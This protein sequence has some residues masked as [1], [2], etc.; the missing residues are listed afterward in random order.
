VIAKLF[1]PG[2]EAHLGHS[3]AAGIVRRVI[4]LPEAEVE[5]LAGQLLTDFSA[6][7]RNY[8]A[9]LERHA[10]IVAA[11]LGDRPSLST[12]R[13][14]VLGAVFTAEYSSEAAALFNPSAVLAPDQD[15][16]G[17][18]QA[19]AALSLRAVGE[20]HVSS[21]GFCTAVV[22]P[23]PLW[24]FEPRARPV[25]L[26]TVSSARWT[27]GRLRAAL[28]GH[29]ALDEVSR[30]LL[31][32]LPE[33]FDNGNLEDAV[34]GLYPELSLRPGGQERI[35]L[36]R[37]LVHSAYATTFD[38]DVTLSQ[39]LLHPSAA[40]ESNGMEDARFTRFVGED[41]GVEYRAT[42]TA[43]DGRRIAPRLLLSRDLRRF[44]AHLLSG[45]AAHNKGMALFPRR[46]SGR[47]FALC[48][49]D[50]ERTSISASD[51]G[52]AWAQ[53][54]GLHSP[55]QREELLQVGNCGPPIETDR[56]WLVLTHA[57]G[58][59]RV[60]TIGAILLDLDDP[61]R[62][63]G[64]LSAPLL[65]PPDDDRDGYVPN[66]VYSCGG[67]VHDGRLWIPYGIDDA[68]IGVAWAPLD[69]L[70]DSLLAGCRP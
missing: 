19:R 5:Q 30:A 41:G 48:R 57:V 4:A 31:H 39:R 63:I 44:E 33:D 46:I 12:A 36:V 51:D 35:D 64:R 43:Y 58:A 17:D 13:T 60:Y 26:G 49:T 24:A 38:V 45:P 56:G 53:P 14:A 47:L 65:A 16:L 28:E 11:R 18:G 66:V 21:I 29:G 34:A 52:Y 23:G 6:R 22:G 67:L 61:S 42:Y 10:S 8:A 69:A 40:E 3:R 27:T 54:V 1:L 68:R 50:G 7:H 2:E 62:V 20:G 15:G 32:A 55:A 59:M 37:R 9:L 25:V 70:L